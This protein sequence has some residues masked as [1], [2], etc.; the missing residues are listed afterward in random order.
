KA[1]ASLIAEVVCSEVPIHGVVTGQA[2]SAAF[3]LLQFCKSR[4]AAKDAQFMFHAPGYNWTPGSD[5]LMSFLDGFRG[6]EDSLHN[7]CL[8][9]LSIRSGQDLTKL[10]QWSGEERI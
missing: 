1:L 8:S 7:F 4:S 9:V 3:D 5:Y 10:K 2:A 6:E